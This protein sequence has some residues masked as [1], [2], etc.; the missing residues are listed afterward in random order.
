M[1]KSSQSS[2][3]W[4][5]SLSNQSGISHQSVST[6]RA[7]REQSEHQNKESIQSEPKILRLVRFVG[8]KSFS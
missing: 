3:F 1:L 4:L 2:S 6:Q 7:L 8:T 5:K